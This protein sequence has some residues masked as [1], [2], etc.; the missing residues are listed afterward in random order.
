LVTRRA[1][2]S[3]L[4]CLTSLLIVT[5]AIYFG[6]NI[7]EVYWR[8]YQFQDDMRQEAK[9]A[10]HSPTD[11][12]LAR[13]RAQA[14][15]LEL[16]PEAHLIDIQRSKTLITIDA[17]YTESLELPMYVREVTFHPHAEGPL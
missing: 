17:E 15:S 10:A 5:A 3:S 9:F 6:V 4:G 12:I 13:L 1:G 16:P 7:G 11:V 8:F 2:S 14:D